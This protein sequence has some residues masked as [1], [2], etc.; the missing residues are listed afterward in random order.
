MSPEDYLRQRLEDQIKWYDDKSGRNK[1]AY[2]WFRTVEI[3][4]AATIPF[5]AGFNKSPCV[6]ISVGVLG[7]LVTVLAG[8]ASVMQLEQRWIEYRTT[9]ESLKKEKYLFLTRVEPY[10]DENAFQ[11]LVQRVETLVSKENTN[12]AQYMMKPTTKGGKHGS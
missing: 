4:S 11:I 10:H 1:R 8:V 6:L 2:T 12:W 5:L 3:G 9:A 7:I